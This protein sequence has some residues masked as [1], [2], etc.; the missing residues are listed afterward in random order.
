MAE[1]GSQPPILNQEPVLR[2]S[3]GTKIPTRALKAEL[4]LKYGL[5]IKFP[6]GTLLLIPSNI[7]SDSPFI[8]KQL[9]D[10][11]EENPV[12]EFI[13]DRASKE[14]IIL[15]FTNYYNLKNGHPVSPD[16]NLFMLMQ[17]VVIADYY[18]YENIIPQIT[19][20]FFYT[21]LNSELSVLIKS[22]LKTEF[23]QL[24]ETICYLILK[25]LTYLSR[26]PI[27]PGLARQFSQPNLKLS[28]LTNYGQVM[29]FISHPSRIEGG[30]K[31]QIYDE[32]HP[33]RHGLEADLR[34]QKVLTGSQTEQDSILGF[35]GFRQG[36]KVI[37]LIYHP[38][39]F[40]RYIYPEAGSILSPIDFIRFR[41]AITNVF[42]NSNSYI[43][44][45]RS[46]II[47]QIMDYQEVDDFDRFLLS[48]QE[49]R[50]QYRIEEYPSRHVLL[51]LSVGIGQSLIV[52][53]YGLYIVIETFI[54]GWGTI[55]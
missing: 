49:E 2:L 45:W 35:S 42:S 50:L 9:E 25:Q 31:Y 55:L 20:Y 33:R 51:F 8:K 43:I 6:D 40:P 7:T 46:R 29:G 5:T 36:D 11:G 47:N 12:I 14:E 3:P 44:P 10:L 34:Y 52:D 54:G 53:D 15:F 16:V 4:A 41:S 17:F 28:A 37:Y 13:P 38:D 18:S 27:E 48:K 19:N 21:L 32:A 39:G 1:L 26:F 24:P 22:K 30:S 23:S